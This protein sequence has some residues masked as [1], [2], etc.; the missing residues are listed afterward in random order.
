MKNMKRYKYPIILTILS[1]GLLLTFQRCGG[2]KG[3]DGASSSSSSSPVTVTSTL[4]PDSYFTEYKNFG[5]TSDSV[6][7]GFIL[8]ADNQFTGYKVRFTGG[9]YSVGYYQISKGSYKFSSEN[10]FSVT[11]TKDTCNDL[12]PESFS[13]SGT[14]GDFIYLKQDTTSIKFFSEKSWQPSAKFQA[15]N[16][17]LVEDTSCNKF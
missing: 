4:A 2:G 13:I 5:G 6:I 16:N 8:A 10:Q 1:L 14:P 17:A 12:N 15:T 7:I 11:Y 3:G 9:N